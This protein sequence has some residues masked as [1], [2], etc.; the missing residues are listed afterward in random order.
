MKILF[1][2]GTGIISSAVASAVIAQGDE[3]FL[4]NRGRSSRPMPKQ[5]R[6]LQADIHDAAEVETVLAGHEFDVVVNWVAFA[7]ADIENDLRLFRNRT[8][9]YIFISSTA[10]Y[11]APAQSLPLTES[12][13]LNNPFWHYA[14]QKIACEKRL[15]R[16][17][18]EDG[19]PMTIVRP[20]HTYDQRSIPA[21]LMAGGYTMI[22][23]LRRHRPVIIHGDGTSLWTLTHHRDFAQGFVGLLG[24]PHAVGD[25]FHITS[26]EVLSWNRIYAMLARGF[27]MEE[28]FIHI[29]S[30]LINAFDARMGAGLL[31]D[32]AHCKIFDNTKIRRLVPGY[33]AV[34][35]FHRGVEEIVRWYSAHESRQ[36]VDRQL[37]ETADR[38]IQAYASAWPESGGV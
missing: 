25:V 36:T 31:G 19:F 3:L 20:S 28:N 26:D 12:T 7:P 29:P 37:D 21:P 4:L 11:Q 10:A 23:R 15:Y 24:H 17:Y 35:P 1:V 27:G 6:H 2:G 34:I 33:K 22:D 14:Q 9:Q 38:I 5:A 8:G 18:R 13:P 30:T 16:A 32:Q